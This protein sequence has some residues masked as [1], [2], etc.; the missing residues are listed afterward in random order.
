M[1]AQKYFPGSVPI[2]ADDADDTDYDAAAAY[3]VIELSFLSLWEAY[4][5]SVFFLCLCF[6]RL[7]TWRACHHNLSSLPGLLS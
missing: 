2:D 6:L 4:R 5:V 7:Y 1:A 3:R